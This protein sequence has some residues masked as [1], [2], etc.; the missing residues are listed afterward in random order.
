MVLERGTSDTCPYG[1]VCST[2]MCVRVLLTMLL[3][4]LC[5]CHLFSSLL[6]DDILSVTILSKSHSYFLLLSVSGDVSAR[7]KGG[8]PQNSVRGGGL[9]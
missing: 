7:E 9:S 2:V 3:W 6:L 1:C 5:V 8:V 4:C